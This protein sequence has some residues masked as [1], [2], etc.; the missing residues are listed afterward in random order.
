M[1]RV[2]YNKGKL[3]VV[4]NPQGFISMWNRYKYRGVV[5]DNERYAT[6]DEFINNIKIF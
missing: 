1:N 2:D 5:K 6:R 4:R 3:Y